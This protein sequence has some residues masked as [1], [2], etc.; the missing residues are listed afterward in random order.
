MD[1]SQITLGMTESMEVPRIEGGSRRVETIFHAEVLQDFRGCTA[2]ESFNKME[3]SFIEFQHKLHCIRLNIASQLETISHTDVEYERLFRFV[4]LC[5]QQLLNAYQEGVL[6]LVEKFKRVSD[7]VLQRMTTEQQVA[8]YELREDGSALREVSSVLSSN[9][10]NR[11]RAS[12]TYTENNLKQ[13]SNRHQE[14]LEALTTIFNRELVD[15]KQR[16]TDSVSSFDSSHQPLFM[17]YSK[18]ASFHESESK[19]LIKQKALVGNLIRELDLLRHRSDKCT[20]V[21]GIDEEKLILLADIRRLKHSIYDLNKLHENR[22]H[23]LALNADCAKS[24]LKREK[25]LAHRVAR[26]WA[27]CA[28]LG[29]DTYA[30]DITLRGIITNLILKSAELIADNSRMELDL[31]SL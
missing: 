13:I 8:I 18:L 31:G 21:L 1:S 2:R 6:S 9:Q 26:I 20:Q 16:L 28:R 27:Q 10:K 23:Q 25:L 11:Q 17:E 19:R 22:L 15:A 12:M 4:G 14:R 7:C 5:S 29:A 30:G 3:V 24:K